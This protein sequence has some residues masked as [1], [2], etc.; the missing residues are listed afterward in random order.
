MDN[1]NK[2]SHYT[3]SPI[4]CIDAIKASMSKD[5]FSGYCKGCVLKYLWR[6]KYKGGIEDLEKATVYLN[7][8]LTNETNNK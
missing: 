6:Y 2:P 8:L 1:V 5:E 7:W 3:F 4:E